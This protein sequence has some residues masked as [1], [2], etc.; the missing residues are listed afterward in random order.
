[1]NC[2]EKIFIHIGNPKAASTSLQLNLFLNHPDINYLGTAFAQGAQQKK[3]EDI[4][5]EKELDPQKAKEISV[6][7]RKLLTL[8]EIS[9]SSSDI[10]D[11]DTFKHHLIPK[12]IKQHKVNVISHEGMTN[13]CVGDTG[14]KA[15]R[16]HEI[17]PNAKVILVI[18][19]QTDVLRSLYDMHPT[20]PL[21][22][23][24][25]GKTLTIESWLDFNF[26]RIERS[27]LKGMLYADIVAYYKNLFGK[28]AVGVFLFEQ[29][30]SNLNE[31]SHQLSGFME[32]DDSITK[33]LL[34]MPPQ[35]TSKDHL[36]HNLRKKILPG[37]QFSKILPKKTHQRLVNQL[38]RY[39]PN[40]KTRI[41]NHY[42]EKI[43]NFY[44]EAN[45]KLIEDFGID[46]SQYGYPL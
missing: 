15:K 37:I 7:W 4:L 39:S 42:Q 46:V 28:D 30:K 32:I 45:Q 8:D 19:N 23:I 18:R 22:G 6:F 25:M 35:H 12:V 10:L 31:F 5:A 14:L 27:Y 36:V 38:T 24:C 20:S 33:K 43:Q 17:F 3:L 16:A 1:M 41:P 34:L 29:L 44:K 26:D 21:T 13:S 11:I 2:K 9:Y 40:I